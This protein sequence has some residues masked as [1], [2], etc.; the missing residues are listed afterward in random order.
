M[1]QIFSLVE[2]IKFVENYQFVEMCPC[3]E[4]LLKTALIILETCPLLCGNLSV[5]RNIITVYICRSLPICVNVCIVKISHFG[6]NL[7]FC[8]SLL[9]MSVRRKYPS[10]NL[11]ICPFMAVCPLM[12]YKPISLPFSS[13]LSTC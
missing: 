6:R 8:G 12:F 7:T 11:S 2:R 5:Y 3:V 10:G 1:E 13:N 4:T 9:I